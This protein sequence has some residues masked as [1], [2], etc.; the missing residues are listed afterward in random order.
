MLPDAAASALGGVLTP[1]WIF[2]RPADLCVCCMCRLSLHS[3]NMLHLARVL[4]PTAVE[5]CNKARPCSC[6]ALQPTGGRSTGHPA[7]GTQQLVRERPCLHHAAQ[8]IEAYA[9]AAALAMGKHSCPKAM[10]QVLLSALSTLGAAGGRAWQ[11]GRTGPTAR[12]G[13]TGQQSTDVLL[14]L[15]T[16]ARWCGEDLLQHDD[17]WN[18]LVSEVSTVGNLP[19][20]QFGAHLYARCCVF[21]LRTGHSVLPL[22]CHLHA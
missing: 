1:R 3:H 8:A 18:A 21:V 2:R 13:L 11:A 6:T 19:A 14:A 22:A 15:A 12:R 17:T 10:D 9:M 20:H 7:A 4:L 5:T 16:V